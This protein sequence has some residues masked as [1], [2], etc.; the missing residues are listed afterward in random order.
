METSVNHAC[1]NWEQWRIRQ[2]FIHQ[3]HRHQALRGEKRA[4]APSVVC[5]HQLVQRRVTGN[6]L[7]AHIIWRGGEQR[8]HDQAKAR[9]AH[10]QKQGARRTVKPLIL[11]PLRHVRMQIE[12]NVAR[13]QRGREDLLHEVKP[14]QL[15]GVLMQKIS[16]H[17]GLRAGHKLAVVLRNPVCH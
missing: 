6:K 2:A 7:K 1:L 4:D 16:R 13:P 15:M 10:A 12:A 14:A 9:P 8:I 3:Q 17:I 11:R 5:G